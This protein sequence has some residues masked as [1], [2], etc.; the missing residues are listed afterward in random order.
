VL[1]NGRDLLKMTDEELRGARRQGGLRLPGPDDQ[2]EPGLHRGRPDHGALR[3]HMGMT[4]PQ[5]EARAVELLELVGIPAR[6]GCGPI[7][8]SFPAAC[9]SG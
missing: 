1:L 4:K 3:K 2:P 9:G 5:A 6:S 8:T 7:R